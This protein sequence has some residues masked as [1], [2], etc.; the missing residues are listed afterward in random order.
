MTQHR[1]GG[2]GIGLWV[3]HRLV[4]AMSG[5]LSVSSNLGEG[6]TFTVILPLSPPEHGPTGP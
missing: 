5:Q 6:T 3:A 4:V 2:F 1:G